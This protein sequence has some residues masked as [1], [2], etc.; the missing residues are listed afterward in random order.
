M[1]TDKGYALAQSKLIFTF[2]E[3]V[4]PTP[5]SVAFQPYRGSARLAMPDSEIE[6][7][8]RILLEEEGPLDAKKMFRVRNIVDNW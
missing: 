8:K 6:K 2:I 5:K 7:A 3:Q 4:L 1:D